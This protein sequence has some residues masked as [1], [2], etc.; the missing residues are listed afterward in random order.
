M[1]RILLVSVLFVVAANAFAA[2]IPSLKY[3]RWMPAFSI[4]KAWVYTQESNNK[5]NG[6]LDGCST[7]DFPGAIAWCMMSYDERTAN[8]DDHNM[9]WANITII[10]YDNWSREFRIATVIPEGRYDDDGWKFHHFE[11]CPAAG[12]T[13]LTHQVYRS[14]EDDSGFLFF[15]TYYSDSLRN[16]IQSIKDSGHRVGVRFQTRWDDNRWNTYDERSPLDAADGN[17]LALPPMPSVSNQRWVNQNETTALVFTTNL[18]ASNDYTMYVQEASGYRSAI[19]LTGSGDRIYYPQRMADNKQ[20][21]HNNFSITLSAYTERSYSFELNFYHDNALSSRRNANVRSTTNQFFSPTSSTP[22]TLSVADL[23]NGNVQVSWVAPNTTSS[24]IALDTSAYILERSTNETFTADYRKYVMPFTIGKTNYVVKDTFSFRYRGDVM[25][26]YRIHRRSTALKDISTN[27][28]QTIGTD[29]ATV[30][31]LKANIDQSN[32]TVYLT[33]DYSGGIKSKELTVNIKYG[34][35]DVNLVSTQAR[36]LRNISIP[37]CTPTTFTLQ[38]YAGPSRHG[39]MQT[40]QISL[41]L[42]TPNTIDTLI[43]S[44]GYFND[45]V[46]LDWKANSQNHS[47]SSFKITRKEYAGGDE[48]LANLGT[49]PFA[50]GVL[51]YSF[52]DYTCVPGVYY[53]YKVVGLTSCNNDTPIE[54]VPVRSVGFAQPLGVISGQITFNGN[55]A[56]PGVSVLAVGDGNHKGKSLLFSAANR[57]RLAV[58]SRFV[59]A[60]FGENEGTIEFFLYLNNPDEQNIIL[61]Y[62]DVLLLKSENGQLVL[63]IK[64]PAGTFHNITRTFGNDGKFKHIAITYNTVGTNRRCN[65]LINGDTTANTISYA[66]ANSYAIVNSTS[67]PLYIGSDGGNSF[68]N[69][70]IDEIRFWNVERTP[71]QIYACYDTYLNGTESGL[72]GYYRCDDEVASTIFDISKTLNTYNGRHLTMSGVPADANKV[73]DREQLSFKTVTDQNGHYLFNNIPFASTGTPYTI[74]PMLGVHEF[75]PASRPLYFNNAATTHNSVDFTDVSSFTV[76]GTVYYYNT[77]Y[78]VNGCQFV[79]DGTTPCMKDG[80][81]IKSNTNGEFTI[82]V[83]IGKHY[84]T[85]QNGNHTFANGGRY[86]AHGL[87]E[88]D[89]PMT[90]LTFNDSSFV[91]V[92]GRVSGGS[93]EAGK[94]HGFAIG[95]A[96]IGKAKIVISPVGA[97]YNLNKDTLNGRTFVMPSNSLQGSCSSVATCGPAVGNSAKYVTIYTDSVTGEFNVMLPPLNFTVNSVEV[98]NNGGNITFASSAFPSLDLTENDVNYRL[99]D[100][101][102]FDSARYNYFY[103]AKALDV[104]YYSYPELTLTQN[105]MN[106]AFGSESFNYSSDKTGTLVEQTVPL[107]TVTPDSIRYTFGYPCYFQGDEWTWQINVSEHY[108]NYDNRLRPDTT[109][110]PFRYGIVTIDNDFGTQ[111]K[112][113]AALMDVSVTLPN[114]TVVSVSGKEMMLDSLGETYYSFQ[115]GDPT[116]FAPYTQSAAITFQDYERTREYDWNGNKNCNFIIFGAKTRGTNMITKAPDEVFYILRDPVGSNSYATWEAGNSITKTVAS[117]SGSQHEFYLEYL[118]AISSTIN[119]ISA[120]NGMGVSSITFEK[121][122]GLGPYFKLERSK[123][124]YD[125]KQWTFVNEETVS[126]SADHAM[127]G[128]CADVYIGKSKNY[129]FGFA[130]QITLDRDA[131]GNF[132]IVKKDVVTYSTE[133]GTQF[134]YSQYYV[135]EFLIPNMKSNR[136]SLLTTVSVPDSL[137]RPDKYPNNTNNTIYITRLHPTDPR[138]GE[139][140][141]YLRILPHNLTQPTPADSSLLSIDDVHSY[142]EQIRQWI[143]VMAENEHAKAIVHHSTSA[144]RQDEWEKA[145]GQASNGGL[146][147]NVQTPGMTPGSTRLDSVVRTYNGGWLIGNYSVGAGAPFSKSETREYSTIANATRTSTNFIVGAKVQ[148]EIVAKAG[149]VLQANVGGGGVYTSDNST[150]NGNTTTVS[151]NVLMDDFE[152]LSFDVY[153]APDG[154]GP[155]FCTRAGQ[156]FCPYEGADS[157]K[158]YKPN[159][160][161]QEL[162]TATI[163]MAKP[164]ITPKMNRAV[165]IPVGQKAIF[166]ITIGNEASTFPQL[167]FV[168]CE[169]PATN[170]N[171]A[172]IK[173]DGVPVS[174]SGFLVSLAGGAHTN[175][176][177]EVQQTRPDILDYDSIAIIFKTNCYKFDA[178]TIY[179]TAHFVPTCSDINLTVDKTTINNTTDT[180]ARFTID[181]YTPDFRNLKGV[182]LQYKSEGSLNWTILKEYTFENDSIA[183]ASGVLHYTHKFRMPAFPDGTYLFRAVT[184]CKSGNET[185]NN[186]SPEIEITFDMT[187]PAALGT[188]YPLD[189]IYSAASQIYV[190]FNEPIQPGRVIADN[191]EVQ[192]VLNSHHVDHAITLDLENNTAYSSATYNLD[193]IPFS[194]EMW[195][196][197]SAPGQIFSYANAGSNGMAL[198]IDANNKLVATINGQ[199]YLSDNTMRPGEWSYL[200]VQLN[201]ATHTLDATYAYGDVILPL[202]TSRSVPAVTVKGNIIFGG[203]GLKAKIHDVALWSCIRPWTTALAE[204]SQSKSPYTPDL[205]SLWHMNEGAGLSTADC[206]RHRDLVLSAD[207]WAYNYTNY[208]LHI[209]AGTTASVNISECPIPQE[210]SYL[211]EFWFRVSGN[212]QL[213]RLAGDSVYVGINNGNLTIGNLSFP[214][215]NYTDNTWHHLAIINK[216]TAAPII[217]IDG[218]QV[219]TYVLT[220]LPVFQSPAVIFGV[221]GTSQVATSD[222]DIDEVRLWNLNTSLEAVR[223]YYRSCMRGT[224]TGLVAYYPMEHT[225][226]DAYN[227]N[228]T[229]FTLMDKTSA[230]TLTAKRITCTSPSAVRATTSPAL[231]ESRPVENVAHTY[232]TSEDK[233]VINITEP[234]ARIEGCTLEFTVRDVVDK[235]G[236][237][238]RPVRWTAFV[239]RNQLMWDENVMDIV[240]NELTDTTFNLVIVNS[241]SQTKAWTIDNVPTWMTLS[242]TY[243]YIQPLQR[244]TI[245]CTINSSLGRGV[246]EHILYLSSDDDIDRPF[247][248]NTKV[249]ANKPDWKVNTD[250]YSNSMNLITC[251]EINGVMADDAEDMVAAFIDDELVGVANLQ[252]FPA[253]GRYYAMMT[254]YPGSSSDN[255]ITF[256]YWDASN[257]S[258]YNNISLHCSGANGADSTINHLLYSSE[259]V[260]GSISNP[261]LLRMGNEIEQSIEMH[262][263]WNWISVNVKPVDSSVKSIFKNYISDFS[264]IKGQNDFTQSDTVRKTVRGVLDTMVCGVGYKLSANRVFTATLTGTPA[265]I[266]TSVALAP[267]AWTWI[268]YVPQTAMTVDAALS[269]INP[270]VGDLIKSQQRFATWDGSQWIGTLSV[271]EPGRGYSYKNTGTQAIAF[272]YPDYNAF[273][274][275]MP[276]RMPYIVEDTYFNPIDPGKYQG[277]MTMTA[278]VTWAGEYVDNAE[279]AVFAGD[280]CRAVATYFDGYYFLTIP[281]ETQEDITIKVVYNDS[282]YCIPGSFKYENDQILGNIY[283]PYEIELVSDYVNVTSVNAT[284]ENKVEKVLIDNEVFIIRNGKYYDAL[285]RP[286]KMKE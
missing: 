139:D 240:K 65:L 237:Y 283:E 233:V 241:G 278:V 12:T 242:D 161:R 109:R 101:L 33:W 29:Y 53:E 59:D 72:T 77:N 39:T 213:F 19:D 79:I 270:T 110:Q 13:Y 128:A 212:A 194:I 182:Q 70:N 84:I 7:T 165:N 73:P 113:D 90:N 92:T 245:S 285:G 178:D 235:N 136:N 44:A 176:V 108:V 265:P 228:V 251:A 163:P 11:D 281:G 140:S 217:A 284:M 34:S 134:H 49:V 142:N 238:S 246:N 199:T 170:P 200:L 45:H 205:I 66:A 62:S 195:I 99:A 169:D 244:Q 156:T 106:K 177:I 151:Y 222:I 261:Y 174:Y 211:F 226:V 214:I 5:S 46:Q 207:A 56:S 264:M 86:P 168:I 160:Q 57:P 144:F 154:F 231:V 148:Y 273:S 112:N 274:D 155:I 91:L 210:N 236:N 85:V 259:T 143:E 74:I 158:Y 89:R 192:G 18:T 124:T 153:Q 229:E 31:D 146:F 269:N 54:S 187:A 123:E 82:E 61:S 232:T 21:A 206:I 116:L 141:T 69:G 64:D 175:K 3:A 198:S 117:S 32:H 201:P 26:Y 184:M 247:Y 248:L 220:Q 4:D 280:E 208:A 204:R 121:N 78:P 215:R 147:A 60:L 145:I 230:D 43:T 22:N 52:T 88:F 51:D 133:L 149:G 188:P 96:T 276:Q 275:R 83:P 243:G 48:S 272:S 119:T 219:S 16:F 172:M 9:E 130:D 25:F 98:V 137:Y 81:I 186:E 40:T 24:D 150:Q 114:N 218:V 267:G 223:L 255:E 38:A 105:R 27:V 252:L 76:S 127:V 135:E 202:F 181:G 67:Y 71:A 37:D 28:T 68:M 50:N 131:S 41:P 185:I 17:F 14:Y 171:G 221:E 103:Y 227:Q 35:T 268:G 95:K 271:M 75:S 234:A 260:Y 189:G 216:I 224:E 253:I 197:Y 23:H 10:D 179:L 157:T 152:A 55:Q 132:S 93:D 58:P 42:G 286:R 225:V 125:Q 239:N 262:P 100:S 47:F 209:P 94:V 254:I 203:N 129:L 138:F 193:S 250:S 1:K 258:V 115:V 104:I 166:N 126:T 279:V 36:E 282:V 191:V 87:Y 183:L 97:I 162:Q 249:I 118:F 102:S 120:P 111:I 15:M 277:N 263:G 196:K 159:G 256:R 122:D 190:E 20:N 167:D 164:S 107:Y 80:E 173:I 6:P 257:G 8:T 266:N 2:W 30:K 180:A 63:R